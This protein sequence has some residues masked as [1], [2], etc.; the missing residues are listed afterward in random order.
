[1]PKNAK[2]YNCEKCDFTCFK[3]SNWDQHL[4]TR[5]HIWTTT[6]D[7]WTTEKNAAAYDENSQKHHCTIC[8]KYYVDRRGLWKHNKKFHPNMQTEDPGTITDK[9]LDV[10]AGFLMDLLKQNNELIAKQSELQNQLIEL[11]KERTVTNNT[12]IN[13][14]QFNLNV[15]LNETCKNAINYN[16]FIRSIGFNQEDLNKVIQNGYVVGHTMLIQ[17]KFDK[18]EVHERPIQCSDPKR[19]VT[20][21]KNDNIWQTDT[22]D[23]YHIKK[24]TDTVT[25][26]TMQQYCKWANE[27]PIPRCEDNS[28]DDEYT[29]HCSTKEKQ[30]ELHLHVMKQVNGI[31][32]EMEKNNREIHKNIL[33]MVTI[34]KSK[35]RGGST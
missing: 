14:Q 27:N 3:K 4:S 30:M 18:L 10:N 13:N 25:H 16:E 17:E 7:K 26:K 22:A 32:S 6:D 31:G 23:M 24:L 5:K 9:P 28:D 35:E 1:M 11:A 15:Y 34:D 21:I 8:N 20:H 2:I 12:Q 19:G 33:K 29:S